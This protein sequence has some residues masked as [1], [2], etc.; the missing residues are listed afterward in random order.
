MNRSSVE[1]F[2]RSWANPL[3]SETVLGFLVSMLKFQSP[4]LVW[5]SVVKTGAAQALQIVR[6]STL[7]FGYPV[8][9]ISKKQW[10]LDTASRYRK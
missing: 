3:T 10:K 6:R 8:G 9:H 1:A 2:E 4:K 5:F 7:V